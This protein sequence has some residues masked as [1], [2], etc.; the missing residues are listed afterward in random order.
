MYLK[1]NDGDSNNFQL[2][3]KLNERVE[4]ELNLVF[5]IPANQNAWQVEPFGSQ[6]SNNFDEAVISSAHSIRCSRHR[7]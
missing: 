1:L 2:S 5:E 7:I 6:L 3:I 4:D